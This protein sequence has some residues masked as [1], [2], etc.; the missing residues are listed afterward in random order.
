LSDNKLTKFAAKNHF[1]VVRNRHYGI[2]N[3]KST[4]IFALSD[5]KFAAKKSRFGG[6]ELTLAMVQLN[7]DS[8]S[9][10]LNIPQTAL[11]TTLDTYDF[12]VSST[13]CSKY[14]VVTL[15]NQY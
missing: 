15:L 7:E 8:P 6:Q 1:L 10:R 4:T 9:L 5:T 13:H 11:V 14:M 12:I 3:V 2:G